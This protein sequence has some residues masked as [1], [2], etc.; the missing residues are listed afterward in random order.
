MMKQIMNIITSAALGVLLLG[1]A[2]F[3][4]G[5][6]EHFQGTV[7]KV[8]NSVLT[9]KTAKGD[10][11][12]KLNAKTEITKDTHAAAVADLKPDTRVV[13]DVAEG[14]KEMKAVSVKIGV[15]AAKSA[16]AKKK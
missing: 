10:V 2:A 16:P 7:V 3:A 4:H 13:V 14:D 15:A 6:F 11:V 5:G 8:D 12:V 9:V 1:A